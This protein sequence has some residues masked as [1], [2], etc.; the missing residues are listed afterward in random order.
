MKRILCSL[1]IATL[2]FGSALADARNRRTPRQVDET[3]RGKGP[4]P[5]NSTFGGDRPTTANKGGETEAYK[6]HHTLATGRFNLLLEQ[7]GLA[8]AYKHPTAT[9]NLGVVGRSGAVR[10]GH[11]LLAQGAAGRA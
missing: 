3:D 4:G 2:P 9:N 11:R 5:K 7:L 6:A 1:L 10:N 8:V